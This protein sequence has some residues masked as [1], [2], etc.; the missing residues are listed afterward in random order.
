LNGR[1]LALGLGMVFAALITIA[2]FYA[3]IV[4]F[5]AKVNLVGAVAAVSVAVAGIVWF[6]KTVGSHK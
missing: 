1:K 2:V 5:F 4:G 6:R 3:L